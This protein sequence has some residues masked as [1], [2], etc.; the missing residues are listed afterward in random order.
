MFVSISTQLLYFVVTL[1][2]SFFYVGIDSMQNHKGAMMELGE[3]VC[4][5][6][7]MDFQNGPFYQFEKEISA[8]LEFIYQT[9]IEQAACETLIHILILELL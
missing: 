3:G 7:K 4:K 8:V 1:F 2:T 6:R 9:Q 5:L